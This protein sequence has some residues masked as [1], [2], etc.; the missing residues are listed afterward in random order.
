LLQPRLSRLILL[1][2][3]RRRN[4]ITFRSEGEILAVKGA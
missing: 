4:S 2:T 3:Q 1:L